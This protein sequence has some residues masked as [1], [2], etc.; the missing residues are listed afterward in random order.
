MKGKNN[1]S[2]PV[3]RF[4]ESQASNSMEAKQQTDKLEKMLQSKKAI[5]FIELSEE[6][7][8]QLED[9]LDQLKIIRETI[10]SNKTT[11][12]D[13][14]KNI[15]EAI[16]QLKGAPNIE[17]NQNLFKD[18]D[19]NYVNYSA[20]AQ[21]YIQELDFYISYYSKYLGKDHPKEMLVDK[22]S[23]DSFFDHLSH[24][25]RRLRNFAKKRSK[26]VTILFSRYD[27]GFNTQIRQLDI[28]KSYLRSNT[29]G[30]RK[31]I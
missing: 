18:F 25:I 24:I 11:I 20:V 4:N 22:D 31:T 2:F 7:K 10:Q 3:D 5:P 19:K 28:V 9:S 8:T 26:D 23:S 6:I 15:K 14:S 29:K 21:F 1:R 27:H 13:K 30:G 17:I 12:N 16:E